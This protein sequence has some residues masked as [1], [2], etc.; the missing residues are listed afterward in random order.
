MRILCLSFS[1]HVH[2]CHFMLIKLKICVRGYSLSLCCAMCS[3]WVVYI[4]VVVLIDGWFYEFAL[5][6]SLKSLKRRFSVIDVGTRCEFFFRRTQF[7][8]F[9]IEKSSYRLGDCDEQYIFEVEHREVY[10]NRETKFKGDINFWLHLLLATATNII[11]KNFKLS[12][13]NPALDFQII[14]IKLI[15]YVHILAFCVISCFLHCSNNIT[16]QGWLDSV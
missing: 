6:I 13:V 4:S 12:T 15:I 14:I 8:I 11:K 10:G 16:S 9:P 7:W 1:F 2:L 5:I 3:V